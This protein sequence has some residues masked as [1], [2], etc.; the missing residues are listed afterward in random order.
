MGGGSSSQQNDKA[1]I[2]LHRQV[3]GH[4]HGSSAQLDKSQLQRNASQASVHSNTN[5]SAGGMQRQ[6]QVGGDTNWMATAG[7]NSQQFNQ[8]VNAMQRL[9]QT[10]G[11]D[12][13]TGVQGGN[14]N[15]QEML[16]Q[17]LRQ[18]QQSQQDPLMM[19]GQSS[20]SGNSNMQMHFQNIQQQQQGVGGGSGD[21]SSMH[22]VSGRIGQGMGGM[23]MGG[24]SSSSSGNQDNNAAATAAQRSFLDG[25][26]AGGWQSNADLPDRR[27]IIF[28]IL[29]VIKQMRPDTNKI[30]QK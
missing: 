24:G 14:M 22:C 23:Q 8:N 15:Q 16:M 21:N 4:V 2:G 11:S 1:S 7:M 9:P 27:H 5:S 19:G 13:F 26:F 18:H 10:F 3:S 29:E 30:S 17:Q 25:N 28:S 20:D 12:A 6:Q